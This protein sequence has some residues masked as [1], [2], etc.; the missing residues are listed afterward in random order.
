MTSRT[1]T[2]S[3]IFLISSL[4]LV[5]CATSNS[6]SP[7]DNEK[8]PVPANALRST[9]SEVGVEFIEPA[10]R[11]QVVEL[12]GDSLTGEPL[13][14]PI[15]N[16]VATVVNSWASWCAPCREELP[17]FASESENPEFSDVGFI[18]LNVNDDLVAAQA[19]AETLPFPSLFDPEGQLLPQ[20]P[21]VPP[22]ALPSTVILDSK[23][24]IA[25]RVIGPVPPGE[26][27]TLIR[28]VI[29]TQ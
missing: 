29:D 24:R 1:K 11:D 15:P 27:A 10:D 6:F 28:Q 23:G 8:I 20:I 9:N 5:G 12:S 2:Y 22:A 7:T 13:D 16:A 21:G 19:M 25:V 14:I 17:E 26:L 4:A 3:A 18:G